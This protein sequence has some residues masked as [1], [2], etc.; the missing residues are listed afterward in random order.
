MESVIEKNNLYKDNL[1]VIKKTKDKVIYKVKCLDGDGEII[2]HHVFPGIYI[3][4]NNFNTFHSFEPENISRDIIEINHCRKG[5]FE[6]KVENDSY[7]YLGEGDLEVNSCQI[8]RE[9]SG[10]PLG[11]YEGVEVLIDIET[12]KEF[13]GGIMEGIEIDFDKMKKRLF[14]NKD[15]FIVRATDEIEHIFHELYNVDERIQKGYF[16][17]KVLELLLFFS[18]VPIEKSNLLSPYFPK[19]QVEKAK[20]IKEHLIDDLEKNVTLQELA[21][22]HEIGLTTLKK[23]FKG[24]YGKSI[25]VWRREYRIYKAASMLKE[26]N[27]TIAE[28][29]GKMGYDNPSKFAS[30]FKKVIGCSPSEYRKK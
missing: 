4:Y 27:M 5:R 30:V 17:I 24:I 15:Y 13:L 19:N 21:Q 16:K 9:T 8:Q 20:H 22:E 26:T 3:I 12:A 29:S 6:C 1:K 14:S 10:F 18:I 23:C 11:Y 28:I 7:I 25:S 2:C